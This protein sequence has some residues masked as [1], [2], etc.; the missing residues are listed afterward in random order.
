MVMRGIKSA[1]HMM[2]VLYSVTYLAR[3]GEGYTE[4]DVDAA[5][6]EKAFKKQSWASCEKLPV[7]RVKS[8]IQRQ[9][10]IRIRVNIQ[11]LWWLTNVAMEG[12]GR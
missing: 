12:R 11:E 5:F 2:R 3:D 9:I 1:V 6:G 4:M 7:I 10:R 8:R